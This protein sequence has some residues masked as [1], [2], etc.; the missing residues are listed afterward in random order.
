MPVYPMRCENCKNVWDE[1]CRF[2]DR[3]SIQCPLCNGT[4]KTF[5]ATMPRAVVFTNPRGTSREDNFDYVAQWNLDNAK[6]IRRQAEKA[7]KGDVKP[8]SQIDDISS[9]EYFGEVK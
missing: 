9:G 7:S 4:K 8:Y 6:D 1:L 5:L 2:D 3:D